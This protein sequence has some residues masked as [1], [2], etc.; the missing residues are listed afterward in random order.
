MTVVTVVD[1]GI[2]NL[3]N[4]L[5]GLEYVG[6]KVQ[7]THDPDRVLKADRLI[8]PGVGA[9]AAGMTELHLRGLDQATCEVAKAGRP[10]LGICLG[11][12]ML[13]DSSTENGWHEGLGLI[14]GNVSPIPKGNK[15]AGDRRRKVPHIGW[16]A[17]HSPPHCSSWDKTCLDRTTQGAFFYFVHSYMAVPEST[18]HVLAQCIYDDLPIVAA[19][20]KGNITGVQFHPERSGPGGLQILERFVSS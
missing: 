6:A 2:V 16:N 1:Y 4:I 10:V 12:Q 15:G 9:F 5:R 13:L 18:T 17:L 14:S 20:A 7:A 8:L 3:G 11:M 19:I